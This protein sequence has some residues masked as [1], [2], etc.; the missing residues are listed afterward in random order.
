MGRRPRGVQLGPEYYPRHGHRSS[1]PR[2][3]SAGAVTQV[4]WCR[5]LHNVYAC[6][7]VCLRDTGLAR[8]SDR[9]RLAKGGRLAG[10]VAL[11]R[12]VL[13]QVSLLRPYQ[14]NRCRG[15]SLE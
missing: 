8:L 3:P 13:G 4:T 1:V 15:G 2:C 12:G 7:N 11:P 5:T 9:R 14:V 10:R 6:L